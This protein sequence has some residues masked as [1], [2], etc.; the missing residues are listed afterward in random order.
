MQHFGTGW[1][2]N[3]G[4]ECGRKT[5]P[6]PEPFLASPLD[7]PEEII[8]NCAKKSADPCAATAPPL[9]Y[10]RTYAWRQTAPRKV[11]IAPAR[12]AGAHKAIAARGNNSAPC[13]GSILHPE[14]D[15]NRTRNWVG[16]VPGIEP[17]L[18]PG[19]GRFD[20]RNW[21]N[22]APENGSIPNSKS[23]QEF[24]LH[25]IKFDTEIGP[26]SPARARMQ[27]GAKFDDAGRSS[28]TPI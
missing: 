4:A 9:T 10:K 14:P 16:L 18:R 7:L 27:S 15:Q 23:G 19:F 20:T 8:P 17:S 25:R 11:A 24:A 2:R 5:W 1:D 28:A 3:F 12:N 21:S 26:R 6:K 22:I 13:I